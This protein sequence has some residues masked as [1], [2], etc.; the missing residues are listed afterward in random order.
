MI[1]N[2]S[3]PVLLSMQISTAM[4]HADEVASRAY[5]AH[6]Y[7]DDAAERKQLEDVMQR[8]QAIYNVLYS[9]KEALQ[10]MI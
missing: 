9:A 3:N 6:Y 4:L 8:E 10:M 5:S 1:I 7:C 2:I